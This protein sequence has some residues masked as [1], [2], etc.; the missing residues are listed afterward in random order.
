[1][2]G[3]ALIVFMADALGAV[4]QGPDVVRQVLP[5]LF[6]WPAFLVALALMAAPVLHTAWQ[7]GWRQRRT[8]Y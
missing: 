5:T 7:T 3:L 8:S 6:H 1:M 2:I 4:R